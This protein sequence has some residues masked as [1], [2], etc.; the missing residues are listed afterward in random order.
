M[1][2]N[3]GVPGFTGSGDVSL[4]E[5]NTRILVNR[6][7]LIRGQ[8][9]MKVAFRTARSMWIVVQFKGPETAPSGGVQVWILLF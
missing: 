6:G 1:Y 9:C 5:G 7:L 2:L 3:G 4:L 8:H